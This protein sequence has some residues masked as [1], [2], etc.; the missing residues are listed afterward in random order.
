[1]TVKD[2]KTNIIT[3]PATQQEVDELCSKVALAT[4]QQRGWVQLSTNH[5]LGGSLLDLA[6]SALHELE[7]LQIRAH[8]QQP[9]TIMLLLKAGESWCAA[10]VAAPG[11]PHVCLLYGCWSTIFILEHRV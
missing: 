8:A 3:Q 11:R 6:D 7:S 4:L 1:M 9:D 2:V 5:L 10:V